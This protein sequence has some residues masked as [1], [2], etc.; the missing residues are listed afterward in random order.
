ML[1]QT[2]KY[3]KCQKIFRISYLKKHLSPV[4]LIYWKC[5]WF[6]GIAAFLR[7]HIDHLKGH[8]KA[9]WSSASE[10]IFIIAFAVWGH[11]TYVLCTTMQS[12]VELLKRKHLLTVSSSWSRPYLGDFPRKKREKKSR[13]SLNIFCNLQT[14]IL[15]RLCAI[16]VQFLWPIIWST[17][18][19][20]FYSS[21]VIFQ[22][23]LK[24]RPCISRTYNEHFKLLCPEAIALAESE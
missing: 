11:G 18:N 14:D 22:H 6:A 19:R 7:S 20:N 12:L 24:D 3:S 15:W 1:N 10:G 23:R 2:R 17:L 16:S 21:P 8:Q 5:T 13:D 9:R 4:R